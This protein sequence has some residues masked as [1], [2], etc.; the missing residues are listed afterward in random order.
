MKT[1]FIRKLT[2]VSTHSYTITIPKALVKEFKWK[3]CQK[4]EI[5]QA[6][7]KPVLTIRDWKPQK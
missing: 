1:L 4:L 7:N 6:G 5:S 3:E 2:K